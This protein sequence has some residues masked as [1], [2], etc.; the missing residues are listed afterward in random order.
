M[1]RLLD[2][3]LPLDE[4]GRR[5]WLETLPRKDEDLVAALRD[6]LL[7]VSM[8]H[9]VPHSLSTL[10]K[11]PAG[12]V[13]T[14]VTDCSRAGDRVGPYLLIHLLGTG[15]MAEVWLA[16]R[17]D[18]A[19]EREVALKLALAALPRSDLQQRFARERDILAALH[20][21]NIALL[22]E[23][24]FAANGQPYLALEY[25]RG[26]PLTSHCDAHRLSIRARLELFQ[27][28]L[29]AVQYAHGHLVIHRDLKPSNIL[30]TEDGQVR[31]LDFG[32]A[33]LLSS[34][35]TETKETELTRLVGR[36]MT[37]EYAAPEQI[38]GGSITTAT[39]VYALGVLL[40]VLL[41]GLQ[42][43]RLKRDSRGALEEA[44]L[45]A[46]PAP[47]SRLG[48]TEIVA[49]ARGTTPQKLRR[50]LR[51]D[52]E[53][54]VSK[55]LKKSPGERYR[56]ADAFGED[57][58]RFMRGEAVLARRDA[59]GYR[60]RKFAR[61]HWVAISAASVLALTLAGG[62]LTTSYEARVANAQRDAAVQ[63]QQ[64]SLTQAAAARLG[65]A[66]LAGTWGI[67][68]EVLANQTAAGAYTPQALSVFQ[69]ARAADTQVLVFG[70]HTGPVWWAAFSPDGR[71]AVTASSDGS[72][73]IW[74]TSTG[75]Q[76]VQFVG[77]DLLNR[78][79]Y[80]HDGRRIVTASRDGSARVWD[81]ATGR[82]IAALIGHTG[83]VESAAFSPDDRR[84]VTASHDR[85]ARVWDAT[86]GRE[87]L[88]LTGHADKLIA[89]A[90]SPDGQYLVTASHDTTARLWDAATGHPLR[91]FIGHRRRVEDA[92]FSPDGEHLVTASTDATARVW[93]VKTG[94]Q[95]AVLSGHQGAVMSAAFS[96]DGERIVTASADRTTRVW[97]AVTGEQIGRLGADPD[98]LQ[99]AAFSPDGRRI[100]TASF[101]KA[102]KIWES[103]SREELRVLR[104]SADGLDYAVFS[105]DGRKVAAACADNTTRI[106]DSESGTELLV[107]RGHQNR[108]Y[109]VAF[110]PDGRRLVTASVDATARIWD[111]A[112][113]R[114]LIRLQ[115]HTGVVQSAVF[116]PDGRRVATAGRDRT[117]RIWDAATGRQ[118]LLLGGHTDEVISAAFSPDGRRIVTA[119][120][121]K[122]AR[123]WDADS[124]REIRVLA[125]HEDWVQA[126]S[127]SRD[128]RRIVT[129][130][131]DNTARVWDADTGAE[132]VRLT[133]HTRPVED[134]AFSPDQQR[135][136]TAS[137]DHTARI[138]DAA[139]G[140]ELLVLQGH[141]GPLRGVSFS[142]DG[143]R[144]LTASADGT[145]RLWDP[146]T[147]ALD[148]QIAWADAAQFDP[149]SA[150]ER[151]ELGMPPA[152]KAREWPH[153]ASLCDQWAA[154]PYDPD[155]RAP[156]LM[157]EQIVGDIARPACA[158]TA[159]RT[160]TDALSLYQHGRALVANG[161]YR[162]ARRDFE[163]AIAAG[164]RSAQVDLAMLLAQ[165]SAGMLDLHRAVLLEEKAW[166]DGVTVA[167]FELGR[168]YENG[169]AR[170]ANPR[171][172]L[173]AP[174]AARAW[175]WYQ[176]AAAAGDPN[177]LARLAERSIEASQPTPAQLLES[178]GYYAAAAERARSEDWPSE[179][180]IGWR[181]QRA[182][183]ARVLA[184]AGMMP[185]VAHVYQDIRR[186]YAPPPLPAWR[187]LLAVI[188]TRPAPRE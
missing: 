54:I 94:R 132:I 90:F 146:R 76:M 128:A 69:E 121:D 152:A 77:T 67:I 20:H 64:R 83:P 135:I 125:G 110:S 103:A 38:A 25:V 120:A 62:M 137:G 140:H 134:A 60:L 11:F 107:L 41:S 5:R 74:D 93:D 86:T 130:S 96:P 39:D 157:L 156:G 36:V 139:T 106:W 66:D 184:R 115:G 102:A 31:L 9:A 161:D 166:K 8:P 27:Q 15:G 6:A 100:V 16:R 145:A 87:I 99:A 55:A 13:E 10:P 129:A 159:T 158:Q 88:R 151:F 173:L 75:R 80:S 61:R 81:A 14:G 57:L 49:Q 142:P 111:A 174:D 147:E 109:G 153:D 164:H 185:Q 84:V 24:G 177:A 112:T 113:G 70:G 46:E 26:T 124:G 51:G 85:S 150:T 30:V 23:A 148:V 119:S 43:Y 17:V 65:D 29:H 126:A 22:F 180:W 165:P 33:K 34:G 35:E 179:A 172:L 63:A 12:D 47:L 188:A 155:R 98:Q 79:V 73:R 105:P 97:D 144:V 116:A 32:I 45:V 50:L 7:P 127:F 59:L 89:A 56:T 48:V 176:K 117:V 182:S 186:R 42:P 162:A 163:R 175:S 143:R 183:L 53:T 18:G 91:R 131:A 167:G 122:T 114:E 118:L 133:G 178:F 154:A 108:V 95:L 141:L 44:I 40:Y 1:S 170:E 181:H 52:I 3:A 82:E 136:V 92:E 149:L 123:I 101:G 71:R 138:W 169:V 168:L 68:L 171:G 21:P 28:V 37:P 4:R 78:A 72:A 58:A 2:E 104:G 19:F 160:N 187:K